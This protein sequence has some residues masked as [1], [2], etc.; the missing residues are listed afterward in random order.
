MRSHISTSKA[1]EISFVLIFN[2]VQHLITRIWCLLLICKLYHLMMG[3]VFVPL[4]DVF[5]CP[6]LFDN[7]SNPQPY[8]M[9]L[10]IFMSYRAES[11]FL[12]KQDLKIAFFLVNRNS[13]C[14]LI[15]LVYMV[16]MCYLLN[17]ERYYEALSPD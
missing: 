10:M 9:E 8:K 4:A 16:Q 12:N 5:G 15:K 6:V 17:N 7:R 14:A 11:C 13:I 1:S 3:I 2:A